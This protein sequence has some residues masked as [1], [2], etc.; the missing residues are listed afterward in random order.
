MLTRKAGLQT[1][2]RVSR[3]GPAS[4]LCQSPPVAG[5]LSPSFLEPGPGR[6]LAGG[7]SRILP[8]LP[9]L[10]THLL[11]GPV[12]GDAS[13]ASQPGGEAVQRV[14][15]RGRGLSA[16][17]PRCTSSLPARTG[18]DSPA[19]PRP[20]PASQPRGRRGALLSAPKHPPRP[21]KAGWE[22]R[23][24]ASPAWSCH[25]DAGAPSALTL[26]CPQENNCIR[27]IPPAWFRPC[28]LVAP[29]GCGQ[30]CVQL[31]VGTFSLRPTVF[32]T[33]RKTWG[34]WGA[35]SVKPLTLDFSSGR[36]LAICELEPRVGLC[37]DSSE[38]GARFGFCVS[39]SLCLSPA[40]A[41]SL[42]QK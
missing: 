12:R 6:S 25:S 5:L 33:R 20:R 16:S 19:G 27:V 22:A 13:G 38:P 4:S 42:S 41:L 1:R 15:P 40:C 35:Q 26:C 7:K 36:D 32:Q 11:G 37:T 8:S 31:A 30:G 21:R 2:V 10:E 18:S 34:A 9:A 14:G 17:K 28:H 29:V 3:C 39:L 24:M 23:W